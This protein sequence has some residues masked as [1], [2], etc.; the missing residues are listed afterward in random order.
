MKI[1]VPLD[2]VHPVQPIMHQ[3]MELV[4]LEKAEVLLLYVR[5]E[6]P[7]YESVMEAV[8]SFKDDLG[9]K[10]ETKAK[11]VLEEAK[12]IIQNRCA[13]V[14]TQVVV[15]P[16][17]MMIETVSRENN[18]DL[19]AIT[20]GHHSQMEKFL[21]GSVT[22]GVVKHCPGT[23][24]ICHPRQNDGHIKHVVMGI[25][26]S[27]QSHNAVSVAPKQFRLRDINP[28]ITLVH[29]VTVAEVLKLVSPVEYISQIE[30]NL[31]MEGETFLAEGKRILAEQG[32]T[33]ITCLLK[34]GD[35]ATL[36]TQIAADLP[37]DLIVIGAQ[38]RTAVQHFLLGS[39]SHRIAMHAPYSTAV[40]KMPLSKH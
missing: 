36:I 15:G 8:G 27:P 6:L 7:S 39:V 29:V 37:A 19:V 32:L 4:G 40:V 13:R 20:P 22:S 25:D 14:S 28:E 34:E 16:P 26:G 18:V 24:L 3:I 11:G 9:F 31:L 10:V 33:K 21:L 1:L 5:E 23:I 35:P 17:A 12:N 2:I 38:G 30:N